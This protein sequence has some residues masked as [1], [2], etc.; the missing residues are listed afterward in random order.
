MWDVHL[1][2]KHASCSK[3]SCMATKE[4]LS[5]FLSVEATYFGCWK[6]SNGGQFP[7]SKQAEEHTVRTST[8]ARHRDH[9][10]GH[11]V[12]IFIIDQVILN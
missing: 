11:H 6:L 3:T 5:S 1:L 12:H 7:R 8:K 10:G 4:E 2:S 9:G